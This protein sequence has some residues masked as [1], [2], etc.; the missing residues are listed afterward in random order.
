MTQ[1]PGCNPSAIIAN[2]Q[3][4]E[5]P[6]VLPYIINLTNTPNF[7]IDLMAEYQAKKISGAQSIFVD[8][9]LNT[10]LLTLELNT[11]Q[12]IKIP[13]GAQGYVRLLM[14]NPPK[15]VGSSGGTQIIRLHILNF[16]T[17]TMIWSQSGQLFTFNGSNELLVSD[18][19]LRAGVVSN[20]YQS[21][22][23]LMGT[24]QTVVPHWGGSTVYN[25][26]NK[27]TVNDTA[28]AA[29][30]GAGLA[31]YIK[32][33]HVTL[34]GDASLA[35]AGQL[36]VAVREA[37]VVIASRIVYLPAAAP[38][39]PGGFDVIKLSNMNYNMKTANVAL[40]AFLG[41]ALATGV[42]SFIVVGGT[43]NVIGP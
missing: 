37:A 23:F 34:S 5:G 9:T 25:L 32:E 12:L 16:P 29:A 24:A 13:P 2:A 1:L 31:Y 41:T 21:Q 8:N 22:G 35:V 6:K 11:Q 30:L 40:N 27:T 39:T 19:G 36:T 20:F 18:P 28:I 42:A 3:P 38:N 15:I 17:D 26:N 14:Q 4:I 43:T 33:I 10:S 7:E